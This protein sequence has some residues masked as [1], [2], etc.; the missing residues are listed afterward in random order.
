MYLTGVV[1]QGKCNTTTNAQVILLLLALLKSKKKEKK[2]LFEG[3][4]KSRSLEQ[5]TLN[6]RQETHV[7]VEERLY[8][9]PRP[10]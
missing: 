5:R 10:L 9:V 8:G 3:N 4:G 2:N 6:V 1:I 7:P